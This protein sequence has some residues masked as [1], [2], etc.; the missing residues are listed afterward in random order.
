MHNTPRQ[1]YGNE[2]RFGAWDNFLVSPRTFY[3]QLGGG[4]NAWVSKDAS[5]RT[6]STL[7]ARF[8]KLAKGLKPAEELALHRAFHTVGWELQERGD[9]SYG[10]IGDLRI[11]AWKT[12]IT[13]DPQAAGMDPTVWWT[14]LAGLVVW[15][16]YALT[17]QIE[18]LHWL[19]L[20]TNLVDVV[21]RHLTALADTYD[22][23]H[24][25]QHAAGAMEQAAWLALAHQ[26]HDRYVTL[27]QRLG[28]DKWIV[29]EQLASEARA[30]GD[31]DLAAAVFAASDRPGI[32][33][34]NLRRAAERTLGKR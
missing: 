21:N 34:A 14:D 4:T 23:V 18:T 2:V 32:M 19:P 7:E 30:S 24:L 3:E 20:P 16:D 10:T 11:E 12:Y 6:C 22:M 5:L 33:Q 13:L 1:R 28:P 25:H 9:D 31:R 26:R 15:D 8:R 27:A 29:V 17:H